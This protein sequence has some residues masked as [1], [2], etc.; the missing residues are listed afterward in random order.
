M[1]H[2][3]DELQYEDIV[4]TIAEYQEMERGSE[5]YVLLFKGKQ[6]PAR[7]LR[8][9]AYELKFKPEKLTPAEMNGKGGENAKKF[10]EN[11]G[12]EVVCMEKGK[13]SNP[14][15]WVWEKYRT[16]LDVDEVIEAVKESKNGD[17]YFERIVAVLDF[18]I[19]QYSADSIT[20][21]K[22]EKYRGFDREWRAYYS[23]ALNL[24]PD[25]HDISFYK[26]V[27]AFYQDDRRDTEKYISLYIGKIFANQ[28]KIT[29]AENCLIEDFVRVFKDAYPG[30]WKRIG[31][32]LS[33]YS[34]DSDIVDE[35]NLLEEYYGCF[36]NE[37][38]IDVLLDFVQKHQD[39]VMPKELLAFSQF[40]F[41]QWNNALAYYEQ[42][43]DECMFLFQ[44]SKDEQMAYCYAKVGD[45]KNA[46]A[47]YKELI[48]AD[49][50]DGYILNE[51]G[52]CLYKQHKYKEALEIFEKG[53][54][55][56]EMIKYI[57]NNIVRT[58][59]AMNKI[60]EARQFANEGK[61]IISKEIL[62]RIEKAEKKSKGK[63][64]KADRPT[65]TDEEMQPD[66]GQNRR[67]VKFSELN[68]QF[69]SEK[70][71]EDEITAKI[72]AGLPVFGL[73]LKIWRRKGE[74]GRQF[75]IPN[76]KRLDLLCEDDKGDIYI[77]ELKKDSGYDDPY[78][79]T[80]EYIDWFEKWDR[81]ANK[82]IYGIICLN[83]PTKV[84]LNKVHKDK[85]IRLFE[86]SIAYEER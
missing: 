44:A 53:L 10:F 4:K 60:A 58:L 52:V 17:L 59:L 16:N 35:C 83:G 37:D 8:K 74:Y 28:D 71:L 73:N 85:R 31:S 29:F 50:Y 34:V 11:L 46:E 21:N 40:T 55:S 38:V 82:K 9:L 45:Y 61:F 72:E 54:D 48:E 5:E 65:D 15:E 79:Q 36:S 77:I 63:T 51:Y 20:H 56:E 57:P 24:L 84:V 49:V 62:K 68:T 6:Y 12:F 86:Y 32:V 13:C 66:F 78:D 81:F 33:S 27:G 42:V 7:R 39:L 80:A 23:K 41:R 22:E 76:G 3:W 64:A 2:S 25:E 14:S 18:I 19:F 30:F 67:D 26:A 69:S 75:I 47:K 43:S 70:L 1:N